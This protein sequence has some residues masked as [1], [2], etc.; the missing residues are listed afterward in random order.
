LSA[1]PTN[2]MPWVPKMG[3]PSPNMI[4]KPITRKAIEETANTMKFLAR[5]VTTFLARQKPDSTL[6]NPRF[7]KN[8]RKA[9]TSTHT[10]SM[11][12]LASPTLAVR[13]LIGS[14]GS[15]GLASAGFASVAAD[16]GAGACANA[17]EAPS[18]SATTSAIVPSRNAVV[19]VRVAGRH[20][21]RDLLHGSA[22]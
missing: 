18:V 13:S 6:A 14:T 16:G 4:P 20:V 2:Q 10:V 5:M 7:M 15:A 9:V 11:A 19:S 3:L 21:G 1:P 12:T 8:T 17:S 22:A